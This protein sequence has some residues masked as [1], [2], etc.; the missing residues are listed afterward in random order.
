MEDFTKF[1]T[2]NQEIRFGKPT[3][4][5]TRIT[6]GDI[7]SWLSC[8]MSFEEIIDDFPEL[9]REHILASLQYAAH[10][11]KITKIIAA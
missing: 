4:I 6:V 9:K 7:L 11:E 5:G 2:L 3:I 8:G 10:R 1:I